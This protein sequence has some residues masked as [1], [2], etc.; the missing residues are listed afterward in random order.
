LDYATDD[1]RDILKEAIPTLLAVVRAE[2][3]QALTGMYVHSHSSH[4]LGQVSRKR[5]REEITEL[6]EQVAQLSAELKVEYSKFAEEFSTIV[7]LS[8]HNDLQNVSNKRHK[9]KHPNNH[10]Q[11]SQDTL[12]SQ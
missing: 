8:H 5:K 12:L 1:L 6:K 4:L 10:N 3:I 7:S 9:S 11:N 2:I